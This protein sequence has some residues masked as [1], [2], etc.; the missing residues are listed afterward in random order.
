MGRI[1]TFT[2]REWA[3]GLV[4]LGFIPQNTGKEL[5]FKHPTIK[6]QLPLGTRFRSYV[7]LPRGIENKNDFQQQIVKDLGRWWGIP[8]EKVIEALRG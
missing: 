6:P 5:K 2:Y 7:T 8:E 4:R 3:Q 1:P